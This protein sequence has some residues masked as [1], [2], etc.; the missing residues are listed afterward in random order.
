[1]KKTT[2][3]GYW[4]ITVACIAFVIFTISIVTIVLDPYFHYH[5]PMKG[6]SYTIYNERYQNDGISRNFEYDTIITGSSMT[7]N[8]KTSECDEIF[9]GTSIKVPY[10]GA[11]YKEINDNLKRAFSSDNSIKYVIRCLD[12]SKLIE[13]SEYMNK[14]VVYPEYMT[15][16]NVF[17]DVNYFLNKTIIYG[18]T[19]KMILNTLLHKESTSF[20][21][22]SNTSSYYTFG[23]EIVLNSYSL[24]EKATSQRELT[25]KEEELVRDNIRKNVVE[26]AEEQKD[27]EFYLFFPPYSICYWD[28]LNQNGEVLWRIQ[29]EKIA[30]EEL[31]KLQNVKLYS[32][33]DDKELVCNLENYKDPAHYGEW[34]NSEIL[35]WMKEEKG[36]LTEENYLQYIENIKE[37]YTSFDYK[38]L[39]VE[40]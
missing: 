20:D 19:L 37:L 22:Y 12:Y 34:V 39:H 8:F 14:D 10:S 32:F 27:T 3:K 21:A 13:S 9:G 36:L 40:D 17:D 23:K 6:L 1:M 7:Q 11:S 31:I 28:N 33:C 24:G 38:S 15:N 30:I 4:W 35:Q 26:L 5:K 25:K 18:D 29:A 2:D 16:E